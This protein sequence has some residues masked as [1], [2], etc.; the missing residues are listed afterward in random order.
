[1]A[2]GAGPRKVAVMAGAEGGRKSSGD[3]HDGFLSEAI[4][5]LDTIANVTF[6]YGTLTK[7]GTGPDRRKGSE[8]EIS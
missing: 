3:G 7:Y 2:G 5:R 4:R 6:I 8:P 1:M